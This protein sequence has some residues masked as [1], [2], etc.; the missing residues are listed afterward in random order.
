MSAVT[1]SRQA[2]F[3]LIGLVIVSFALYELRSVLLPFV[4]GLVVA[5]CFDPVVD[6]F[7]RWGASRL[8][9]TII[10]T[11]FFFISVILIL[12][13]LIPLLQS[14]IANFARSV[15]YYLDSLRDLVTGWI[16]RNSLKIDP[17]DA[18][19]LR[20]FMG[21]FAGKVFG[22]LGGILT[23][24]WSGGLALVNL[25]SLI[26]ITPVIAFY[27]LR[28]WGKIIAYIDSLLP[29]EH[30]ETIRV[31]VREIDMKLA[32][33]ARGQALVCLFLGVFYS[34]GLAIVGLQF[35]LIV[36]IGAGLLSFIPFVGTIG[37]FLTSVA[38]AFFQFSDWRW[39]A[40]T[41]AVFLVGN[42]IE[43]NILTPKLI[44]DRVGLH[45]VWVIFALL[46]GGALLG[47]VGVLLA[48]PLAASIG[49]L[50]RFGL[51]R[52]IGSP[53]YGDSRGGSGG[54]A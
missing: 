47:F 5:Y 19:R 43:A 1:P 54:D 11:A 33:F 24:L 2:Y 44:G 50:A 20:A 25:L 29:R 34:V 35:G 6:R 27:C 21:D 53:L 39:I 49:V 51:K 45:P 10:V 8:L 31:L 48:V 26:F 23:G 42:L 30:A 36:G 40:A 7:E 9:A 3:W 28:D 38:L 17:A 22:W 52:Y 15:P 32:S 12:F 46:A 16:Q 37:G 18:E 4:A 41:A 14:D 13:S